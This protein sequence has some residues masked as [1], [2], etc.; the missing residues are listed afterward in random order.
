MP[1][2]ICSNQNVFAGSDHGFSL[3]E[4]LIALAVLAL[5]LLAAGQL[6][7]IA[8]S[9]RSLSRCKQTAAVVAQNKLEYLSDSYRRD[10]SAL[11]LALGSHGPEQTR[12]LNPVNG[13][14][15]NRYNVTWTTSEVA[16]PRP[17]KILQARQVTVTVIP[18]QSEA[19]ANIRAPLNKVLNVTTIFS[20]MTP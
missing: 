8:M 6:I 18:I 16:D 13:S 7:C 1:S 17:G 12:V 10:P 2:R 5:G 3:T 15:L 19:I 9:S 14:I 20:A 11:E 4:M